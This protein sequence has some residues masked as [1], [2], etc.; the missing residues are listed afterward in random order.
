MGTAVATVTSELKVNEAQ[1]KTRNTRPGIIHLIRRGPS[2]TEDKQF[3]QPRTEAVTGNGCC[4][5]RWIVFSVTISLALSMASVS[6]AAASASEEN[7]NVSERFLLR[8]SPFG[9]LISPLL[10]AGRQV[11]ILVFRLFQGRMTGWVR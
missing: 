4:F 9:A 3:F 6:G 11:D 7:E 10:K 8:M 1:T 2:E 5:Q